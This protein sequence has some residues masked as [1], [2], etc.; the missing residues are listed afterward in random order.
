M[1]LNI[2]KNVSAHHETVTLGITFHWQSLPD[3][4]A[5]LPQQRSERGVFS[6]SLIYA[7]PEP[8]TSM[9]IYIK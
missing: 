9:F 4:A 5:P 6:V 3:Q 2:L 7:S 1:N 8:D